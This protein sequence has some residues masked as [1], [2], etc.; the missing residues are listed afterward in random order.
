MQYPNPSKFNQRHRGWWVPR[1]VG[2]GLV[3]LIML[4]VASMCGGRSSLT[5]PRSEPTTPITIFGYRYTVGVGPF[6]KQTEFQGQSAT[7]GTHFLVAPV[8]LH[9]AEPDRSAPVPLCCSKMTS[10]FLIGL[11]PVTYAKP[12]D[13]SVYTD[14]NA[15]A[16][17]NKTVDHSVVTEARKITYRDIADDVCI[18]GAQQRL[19]DTDSLPASQIPV[20][21]AL[22][23][24]LMAT[25]DD[26][27]TF[28]TAT[29]W[30]QPDGD[31]TTYIQVK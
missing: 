17:L 31:G 20:G 18:I 23:F 2:A 30:V 6:T 28:T 11:A 8:K 24:L 9:D 4:V 1:M 26:S 16:C 5:S 21:Q 27:T 22:D 7:P 10:L 19:A 3:V 14:P 29:A 13:T 15:N 12:D 25:V